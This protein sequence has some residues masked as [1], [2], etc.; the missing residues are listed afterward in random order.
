LT[1]RRSSG[2]LTK[3]TR[4][5]GTTSKLVLG[6][7]LAATAM[8]GCKRDEPQ[9]AQRP[10]PETAQ[11]HAVF[12]P[13][14][15]HAAA[16]LLAH[17][18][19]GVVAG[20]AT[21]LTAQDAA[22]LLGLDMA[23][24]A[25]DYAKAF[26]SDSVSADKRFSGKHLLVFATVQAVDKE[27]VRDGYISLDSGLQ[28]GVHAGLAHSSYVKAEKL[29]VHQRVV[30][31]CD[32]SA[33][34]LSEA[35]LSQCAFVPEYAAEHGV[36]PDA[37]AQHFF[38]GDLALGPTAYHEA[39]LGY[40]LGTS[41]NASAVCRQRLDAQSCGPLLAAGTDKL[42]DSVVAGLAKHKARPF[43]RVSC[44]LP[45]NTVDDSAP[46]TSDTCFRVRNGN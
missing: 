13:D 10:N 25:L 9:F 46:T 34:M 35:T 37:Q 4:H 20:T 31:A 40:A 3:L 45:N 42:V 22:R 30:M 32:A 17:D 1:S 24:N 11:S 16:S 7:T 5:L 26:D 14:G 28:L 39:M 33:Q 27:Y 15:V 8:T 38:D 41:T 18:L 43:E 6:A 21:P 36:T 19:D 23:V 12:Q 2:R 44:A 29:H